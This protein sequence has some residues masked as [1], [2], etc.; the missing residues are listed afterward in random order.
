MPADEIMD[1]A[2]VQ[3]R[4][5]AG[6]LVT[7]GIYIPGRDELQGD[8]LRAHLEKSEMI[9]LIAYMQKLGAYREVT[10]EKPKGPT[11]LDPDSHREASSR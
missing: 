7:A 6:N 11:S 1:R 10:P 9:A 4:E 3:A 5:I 8:A 2:K